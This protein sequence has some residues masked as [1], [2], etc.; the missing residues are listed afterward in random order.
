LEAELSAA[1]A[2]AENTMNRS[3]LESAFQ[4][5]KENQKA[6]EELSQLNFKHEELTRR[7]AR[8]EITA[9]NKYLESTE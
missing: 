6:F 2:K 4:I 5:R 3:R 8:E 9:H 1:R 7:A